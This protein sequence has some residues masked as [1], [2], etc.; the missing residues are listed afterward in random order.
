MVEK[1]TNRFDWIVYDDNS[2]LLQAKYKEM[3]KQ[4]EAELCLGLKPSSEL[5]LACIKLEEAFM[6]VGKSVKHDQIKR[7]QSV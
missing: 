4:L 5:T 1:M 2:V 7:E 6:W 3:F